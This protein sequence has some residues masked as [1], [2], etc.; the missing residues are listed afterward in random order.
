[1]KCSSVK[2]DFSVLCHNRIRCSSLGHQDCTSLGQFPLPFISMTDNQGVSIWNGNTSAMGSPCSFAARAAR[3][4]GLA[5]SGKEPKQRGGMLC[6]PVSFAKYLSRKGILVCA[7]RK[8]NQKPWQIRTGSEPY[9]PP[10][11]VQPLGGIEKSCRSTQKI[12][13]NFSNR[14][15]FPSFQTLQLNFMGPSSS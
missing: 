1:M 9:S 2:Q 6:I 8:Q 5:Y 11:T 7:H 14:K 4:G 3:L 10:P 15:L 12:C 13:S